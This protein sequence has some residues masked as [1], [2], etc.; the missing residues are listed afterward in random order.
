MNHTQGHA[1]QGDHSLRYAA[2]YTRVSTEDQGKGYSIPTQ[3]EACKKL[4]EREGYT[5]AESHV[6]VDEGLSG[7]TMDRPGLRQVRDIV[8][9]HAITG[10]IVIDPDRL[11]RNL[12]HQLLLAEEFERAG[13]KLLIVS[14]PLEQGPEGWLFFQMRGALAEYERAKILERTKR[15][16]LGRAKA[17]HA[18][19][20]QVPLGYRYVAEPHGGRLEIREEEAAIVRGIFDLCLSGLSS[21][22]IARRL[23]ATRIPTK[24]D[25]YPASGGRKSV[26]VGVWNHDSVAR[27][28]T[29]ETYMGTQYWNKR[30]RLSQTTTATRAREEW[31]K[32]PV[33]PIISEEVFTA[34]RAQ[35]DKNKALAKRNRKRHYLFTGGRLR[36]GRCGR[37]M[38]GCA[39]KNQRRYRCSSMTNVA[40]RA[41]QCR[42]TVHADHTEA[43]VWA[44][45]E[46]VLQQPELILAE[47]QRQHEGADT[48]R[49]AYVGELSLLN[50]LLAKC[51]REDQRW[52][53]AYVNESIDEGELKG[54]RAEIAARRQS[55]LVECER[56]Q[57]AMADIAQAVDHV[58]RLVDYCTRVKQRLQTFNDAEKCLALEAL[59]VRVTWRPREPLAIEGT[60]PLG[61][62]ATSTAHP[63]PKVAT[64]ITKI[65]GCPVN[66]AMKGKGC[67][68]KHW[69]LTLARRFLCSIRAPKRGLTISHGVKMAHE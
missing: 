9:A 36:C 10:V 26:G 24:R 45:I 46:Q 1:S 14:H 28:L 53:K 18:H 44:V 58:E 34:V 12:G 48:Q 57:A 61:D 33:P 67:C 29:N 59:D 32:I 55:L 41:Y 64:T 30:A 4:A 25:R 54:Y 7:T 68:S 3:I 13:V 60:I 47:V 23:T 49:A 2:I 6:L 50:D 65:Y 52:L 69:T 42:E 5:V 38:V 66:Y 43:R 19:G 11:S 8:N 17:G 40:D 31:V 51:D 37:A 20:G 62:I 56:I 35:L 63:R 22:S 27:M 16:M 21:W 15:G 39:P